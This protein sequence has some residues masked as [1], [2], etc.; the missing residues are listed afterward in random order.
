MMAFSNKQIM[1]FY[2]THTH[3]HIHI[4]KQNKPQKKE[5]KKER[6]EYVKKKNPCFPIFCSLKLFAYILRRCRQTIII[7]VWCHSVIIPMF[8]T[9]QAHC[10][11]DT[12]F[13]DMEDSGQN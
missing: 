1:A 10:T 13:D 8:T 12:C 9:G 4:H 7:V 2:N 3:I 11:V 5:R 6:K